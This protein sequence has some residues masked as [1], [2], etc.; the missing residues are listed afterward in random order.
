MKRLIAFILAL[1]LSLSLLASCAA[2]GYKR[3][4]V[5]DASEKIKATYT[6][7]QQD[8]Y[9]E[10]IDKLSVFSA[11]LTDALRSL[12]A[13]TAFMTSEQYFLYKKLWITPQFFVYIR[14]LPSSGITSLTAAIAHSIIE[15]SGSF[16]VILCIRSPGAEIILVNTLSC[17]PAS[18]IS[19]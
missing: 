3:Y 9:A 13:K 18:F 11:R 19:S 7:Y 5:A 1:S 14:S 12:L 6:D 15:S 10:F 8:G 17:L 4:S 16:V 2:L